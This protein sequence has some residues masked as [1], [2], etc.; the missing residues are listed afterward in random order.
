MRICLLPMAKLFCKTAE[1]EQFTD[2]TPNDNI[3]PGGSDGGEIRYFQ[4]G[5]F[6]P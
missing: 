3:S 6:S 5:H 1:S 2:D 4:G